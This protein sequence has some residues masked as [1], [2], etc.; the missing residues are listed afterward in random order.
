MTAPLG[1]VRI[2]LSDRV[3]LRLSGDGFVADA[4][5]TARARTRAAPATSRSARRSRLLHSEA[6]GFDA[7]VIPMVT[8][9]T[10]SSAM[11]SGAYDP[12]LKLTYAKSLGHGFDLSGNVNFSR[13][14]DGGD[15]FSQRAYSVS[16]GHELGENWGAVLGSLRVLAA[17]ERRR[18]GLDA[19]HRRLAQPRRQRADRRRSR[20]RRHRGGARIGLWVS[21]SRYATAAS[22]ANARNTG[23]RSESEALDMDNRPP[24]GG[25]LRGLRRHRGGR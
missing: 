14:T 22:A 13:V 5:R 4:V 7:A 17:G 3:E 8:V 6:W 16:V 11:S 21:A 23:L 19:R 12:T 9:P 20:P 2:G 1:L 15:V 10:G 24:H 18:R 25:G